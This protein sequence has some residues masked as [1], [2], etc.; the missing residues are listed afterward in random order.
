MLPWWLIA[1]LGGGLAAACLLAS[2]AQK[3]TGRPHRP[4]L[5][6]LVIVGL[7]II[8]SLRP[9]LPGGLN[10]SGKGLLDVY[11]VM[12]TTISSLAEDYQGQRPRIEGMRQD[13]KAIATSLAGARFSLVT[14]DNTATQVLPLTHDASTLAAAVDTV[15]VQT[16]YYATGSSID[17]AVPLLKRELSRAAQSAPERGRI[18]I[19]LGDGEQTADKAPGSFADLKSLIKGGAVLGYGSS[20]GGRMRDVS[21][22]TG[23][24]DAL[25]LK[26]NS[27]KTDP[28]P[29]ALSKIDEDNLR[30]IA[31]QTGT[32]YFHRTQPDNAS[33]ITSGIDIGAIIG[34]SR[35]V[36]SYDDLYWLL[37]PLLLLLVAYDLWTTRVA[38]RALVTTG[39]DHA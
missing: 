35:D 16:N 29:D 5:R 9:S 23:N 39:D 7:L 25:Y 18:I 27:A 4:W 14:F 32:A 11:I 13:I 26:D 30:R 38:R 36:A 17:T 1:L 31:S 33:A 8:I 10:A 28:A 19:Y 6:R 20:S 12:D 3:R 15:A 21:V 34:S 2:R 22:D 24:G 37:M